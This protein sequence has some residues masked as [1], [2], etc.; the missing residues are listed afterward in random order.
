VIGPLNESAKW[1]VFA[2]KADDARRAAYWRWIARLRR[3]ETSARRAAAERLPDPAVEIPAAVGHWTSNGSSLA[4]V[5][6]VVEEVQRIRSSI[7]RAERGEGKPYLIDFPITELDKSS[8]LLQFALS[9]QVVTAATRYLG[10]VPILTGVTVLAS[11]YIESLAFAGSQLF[12]SDWEDRRQV[13]VFV[14]CSDV[15]A[16]NGP[17]TAVSAAASAKVKEAVDYHYGGPSFRLPDDEVLPRVDASQVSAFVGATGSVTFIDTSSC[18][19]LGSR[20]QR[21]AAERL[22]VQFQFLTPAAFDLQLSRRQ[23]ARR[24][25]AT[26]GDFSPH[27]RLVLGA[28]R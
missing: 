28:T 4:G 11:P 15:G 1:F 27:Q 17:L 6:A 3:R 9:D 8:P 26:K 16:E 19:H 7:F 22:V 20:M 12:H 14:H 5:P 21:G 10:M 13:K 23:R 25:A 18:L 2:V 24:F